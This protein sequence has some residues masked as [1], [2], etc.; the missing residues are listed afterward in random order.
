MFAQSSY[1]VAVDPTPTTSPHPRRRTSPRTRRRPLARAVGASL[2]LGLL[3]TATATPAGA[4]PVPTA[5]HGPR[6]PVSTFDRSTS[7]DLLLAAP[8]HPSLLGPIA[9]ETLSDATRARAAMAAVEVAEDLGSTGDTAP[10]GSTAVAPQAEA[11][12]EL[13]PEPEPEPEPQDIAV[14][15]AL[16][17]IG[18]PYVWGGSGPNGFDCSG[19]TMWA[20]GK[21]GVSLGHYTGSQYAQSRHVTEAELRPGDLVFYWRGGRG[22]DPTHVALYLG[23]GNIVHA[24]GRGRPVQI[25]PVDYW[26]GASVAFGRVAP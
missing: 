25:Q 16:S 2:A 24:P 4:A 22:G 19:L 11:E 3:A 10:L 1:P 20:W 6:T 17:E 8:E 13:E 23:D 14:W 7:R 15:S 26:S 9:T 12:P 21:A 5:T 18:T